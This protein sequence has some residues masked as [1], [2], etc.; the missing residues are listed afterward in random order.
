MSRATVRPEVPKSQRSLSHELLGHTNK[1]MLYPNTSGNV[2]R[3]SRGHAN[4]ICL[5]PIL[6]IFDQSNVYF[7]HVHV[8]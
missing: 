3:P 4:I 1:K 5:V 2:H 6:Q 8:S 7:E